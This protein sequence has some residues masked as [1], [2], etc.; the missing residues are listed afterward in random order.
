MNSSGR[1]PKDEAATTST[2]VTGRDVNHVAIPDRLSVGP[3]HRRQRRR[4]LLMAAT[5]EYETQHNMR[6]VFGRIESAN[7]KI[8]LLCV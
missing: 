3:P 8:R 6:L 2:K 1:T 5:H 7:T 4:Q